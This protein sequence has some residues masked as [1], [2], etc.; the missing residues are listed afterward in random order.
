MAIPA[1]THNS[2]TCKLTEKQRQKTETEFLRNVA[3]Y[4]LKAQIRDAVIRSKLN[5]SRRVSSSGMWRRVVCWV[6]TDGGTYRLHLQGQRNNFSKNQQVSWWLSPSQATCLFAGFYWNYFFDPKDGGDFSS[7]TS[8]ATQ[9]T[10]RR[11]IPEDDTLHNHRCENLK[12]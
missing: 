10:T 4:T 9:Q 11:H 6:A 2:G 3:G 1:L 7:E 12:S 5:I 8:D